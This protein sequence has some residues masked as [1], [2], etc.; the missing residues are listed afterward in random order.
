[1]NAPLRLAGDTLMVRRLLGYV[2]NALRSHR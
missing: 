2:P 1:M